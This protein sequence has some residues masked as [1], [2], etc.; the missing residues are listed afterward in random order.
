MVSKHNGGLQQA[1]S[2]SKAVSLLKIYL[3]SYTWLPKTH[4]DYATLKEESRAK[5]GE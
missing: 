2:G 3:S 1:Y 4:N 5:L